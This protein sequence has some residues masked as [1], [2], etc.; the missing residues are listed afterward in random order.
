M[1]A[2][3]K[4]SAPVHE[5]AGGH[6]PAAP[7]ERA[8]SQPTSMTISGAMCDHSLTGAALFAISRFL[9]TPR[10]YEVDVPLS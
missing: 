7:I 4:R 2:K 5:F 6:T 8:T 9:F 1:A 3:A 10:I